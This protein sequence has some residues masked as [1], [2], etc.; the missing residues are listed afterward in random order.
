M[1]LRNT[2]CSL[3]FAAFIILLSYVLSHLAHTQNFWTFIVG[4][5]VAC[6]IVVSLG[7]AWDHYE[8]TRSQR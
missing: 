3:V 7:F 6:A 2:V 5:A 8:R 4:S 1:T